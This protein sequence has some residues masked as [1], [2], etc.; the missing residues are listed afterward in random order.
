MPVIIGVAANTDKNRFDQPITAIPHAYV[1][2]I[3]RTGAIPVILPPETEQESLAALVARVDGILIPGGLDIDPKAYGQA[4]HPTLGPADPLLDTFQLALARLA[5]VEKKPMLGI[6]R[7]CQVINVALGGTLCQDIP[8]FFPQS[9]LRHMQRVLTYDTDHEVSLTPGSRLFG[10]FGP[11]MHINSRHHQSIETPG[12]GLII[13]AHAPDGVIEGAEH[14]SLPI[15]LV[16]WH[17]ELLM[18]KNDAMLPLFKAFAQRCREG[19]A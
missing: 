4:P 1:N 6:C 3:R 17:P 16:Q 5:V 7:G 12:K 9:P 11:S 15:D 19:Q 14:D 18:Q 13:T 8:S 10:L 2:S